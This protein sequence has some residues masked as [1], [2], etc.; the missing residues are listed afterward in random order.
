MDDEREQSRVSYIK[1]LCRQIAG[2]LSSDRRYPAWH[3]TL[4]AMVERDFPGLSA[5]EDEAVRFFVRRL[6]NMHLS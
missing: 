2:H 4:I 1:Q 6:T 5:A 3:D